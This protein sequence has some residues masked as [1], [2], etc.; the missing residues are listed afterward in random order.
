[1]LFV[2][3]NALM[4]S[5][6]I[7]GGRIKLVAGVWVVAFTATTA[8]HLVLPSGWGVAGAGAAVFLSELGLTVLFS[9]ALVA[10]HVSLRPAAIPRRALAIAAAALLAVAAGVVTPFAAERA[11]FPDPQSGLLVLLVLPLLLVAVCLYLGYDLLSPAA[12]FGITWTA[13]LAIA[14]LPLYPSFSWSGE[15]WTLVTVPPFVLVA[16]AALASG[17]TPFRRGMPRPREQGAFPAPTLLVA[18]FVAAGLAAWAVFY[19]RLGTIPLFPGQS[20]PSAS[21]SSTSGR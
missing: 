21:P 19:A 15:M 14:Q 4:L 17:T 8:L 12:L 1:M 2:G 10:T 3:P 6:L 5:A 13:A 7:A 18:L 9:A 16:G 11:A 20:M